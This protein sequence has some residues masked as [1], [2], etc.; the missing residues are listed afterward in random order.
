MDPKR[1]SAE[2]VLQKLKGKDQNCEHVPR[3]VPGRNECLPLRLGFFFDNDQIGPT[4]LGSKFPPVLN[5]DVRKLC[6]ACYEDAVPEG[7]VTWSMDYNFAELKK[8]TDGKR[9]ETRR[10]GNLPPQFAPGPNGI[11]QPHLTRDSGELKPF[12]NNPSLPD[13]FAFLQHL[14]RPFY[15]DVLHLSEQWDFNASPEKQKKQLERV[16]KENGLAYDFAAIVFVADGSGGYGPWTTAEQ[17][18]AREVR[19]VPGNW[20]DTEPGRL[21]TESER[22]S[23]I[24]TLPPEGFGYPWPDDPSAYPIDTRPI[25]ELLQNQIQLRPNLIS[26]YLTNA[27]RVKESYYRENPS[28]QYQEIRRQPAGP[29]SDAP[30]IETTVDFKGTRWPEK[31][32]Y[33]ALSRTIVDEKNRM[34][35]PGHDEPGEWELAK[36]AEE[37][38][39]ALTW[40]DRERTGGLDENQRIEKLRELYKARGVPKELLQRE[41]RSQF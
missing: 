31:P 36:Y 41:M 2:Y 27:D 9:R 33:D 11:L 16:G 21:E 28:F 14:S 38:G 40:E 4:P 15:L 6:R 25:Q 24:C 34:M 18:R 5:L 32:K 8:E 37:A 13:A 39:Q 3:L 20:R 7:F 26:S 30:F 10:Y 12:G 35:G 19:V 29:N 1:G 22:W 17:R 23:F